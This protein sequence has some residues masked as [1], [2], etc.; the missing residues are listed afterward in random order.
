[1]VKIFP[2]AVSLLGEQS[3]Q[4][5]LE[6]LLTASSACAF[7]SLP[8]L[9]SWS[10]EL[11]SLKGYRFGRIFGSPMPKKL[12]TAIRD[13][14]ARQRTELANERTLL[15]YIRTAMG[16]LL[17]VFRL[18]GGWSC[19]AFK[20]WVW[21]RWWWVSRSWGLGFGDSS[22]SKRGSINNRTRCADT[23]L[24]RARGHYIYREKKRSKKGAGV[25]V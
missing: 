14:L 16:F 6:S 18:C 11:R 21:C 25:F 22:P 10:V 17:L 15:S 3:N 9:F 1:M 4:R 23:H 20:H 19:L 13:R 7:S 2:A 5:G 12:D 24:V 8:G